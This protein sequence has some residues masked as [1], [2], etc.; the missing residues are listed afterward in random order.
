[1]RV[2]SSR[3]AKQLDLIKLAQYVTRLHQHRSQLKPTAPV[4]VCISDKFRGKMVA[5]VQ[6]SNN[7]CTSSATNCG[8]VFF[9]PPYFF[10]IRVLISILSNLS[11]CK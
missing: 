2:F 7:R 10:I 3:V 8:V 5:V 6:M 4:L 1:M 11:Q 9:V